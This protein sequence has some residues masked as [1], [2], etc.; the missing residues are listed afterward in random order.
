MCVSVQLVIWNHR[1]DFKYLPAGSLFKIHTVWYVC[2]T[3]QLA[4]VSC[5]LLQSILFLSSQV[6]FICAFLN[7]HYFKVALQK[8][9][10]PNSLTLSKF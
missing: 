7:T 4:D 10:L 8:A 1:I 2:Y 3:A 5:H 6:K 9:I